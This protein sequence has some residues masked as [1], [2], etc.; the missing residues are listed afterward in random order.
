MGAL[1]GGQS[2]SDEGVNPVK[3][4]MAAGLAIILTLGP[5]GI[6][7]FIG[8]SDTF[9]IT[10]LEYDEDDNEISFL[11]EGALTKQ[12]LPLTPYH[13]LVMLQRYGQNRSHLAITVLDLR[14]RF[15]IFSKEIVKPAFTAQTLH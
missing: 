15:K 2:L 13:P 10:D 8:V 7:M 1:V 12:L 11:V 14:Y 6:G 9:A 5:Y 3:M 4:G